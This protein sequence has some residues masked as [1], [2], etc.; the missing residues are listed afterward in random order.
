V[1]VSIHSMKKKFLPVLAFLALCYVVAWSMAG[2]VEKLKAGD[3]A[4]AVKA[5]DIH[6]AAVG[7]PS[8]KAKFVHLQFRRFAGC[9]ICNLHV[10]EFVQRSAEL[11]G[12]GIQ[13]VV[14]Y[15][16]PQASLIPYQ[17]K[18]PFAV[19]ADPEKKLYQDFGVGSSIFAILDV[20]A[21]PA[22]V[23]GMAATDKPKGD[24][25]G[26][27]FGRPAD[28]LIGPDGKIVASHYG[29]HAYDQWSV[30]QVLALVKH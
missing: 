29:R 20:R 26:G 1:T 12:A 24:P 6:G 5:T 7:I 8:P 9:P 22:M 3:V 19:I 21:W 27:P 17:G 15:H 11:S 14:V 2:P 23:K 18:F 16:S 4:P 13:E 25:E 10:H 28:F 30:D